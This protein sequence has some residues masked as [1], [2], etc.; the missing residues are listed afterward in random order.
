MGVEEKAYMYVAY[1]D[2][3]L[4]QEIPSL[5]CSHEEADTRLVWH[6]K[7]ICETYPDGNIIVRSCDN[8]VLGILLAHVSELSAQIWLDVGLSSNNT[9]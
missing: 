1:Q 3:I 7:H 6:L 9:R 4:C 8:D 5:A 2:D